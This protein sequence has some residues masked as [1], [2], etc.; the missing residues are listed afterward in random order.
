MLKGNKDKVIDWLR[1]KGIAKAAK[2]ET[3][4][5]AKGLTEVTSDGNQAIIY[6]VN[7]KTDFVT[8]NEK[9]SMN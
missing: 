3:R 9:N 7:Y 5:A 6:E 4:I 2:K 8:K 1:E